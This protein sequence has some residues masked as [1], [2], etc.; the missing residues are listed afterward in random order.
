MTQTSTQN[1]RGEGAGWFSQLLVF[2]HT[3]IKTKYISPM[4][5]QNVI[6]KNISINAEV[7]LFFKK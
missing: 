4:V 2:M 5:Q 1:S 3:I 7:A 6:M